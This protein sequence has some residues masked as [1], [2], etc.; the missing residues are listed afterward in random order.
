MPLL[1]EALVEEW[2]NRQGYF[3]IRG[4]RTGVD[5]IDLLAV[6]LT[7]GKPE[8]IHVEA[9]VSFNPVGYIC[10]LPASLANELG[11]AR[12]SAKERSREQM[13]LAT[14][15]WITKKFTQA[16]KR[17][18]RASLMP[19]AT[20]KFMFVHGNVRSAI[21]LELL[22]Q[23]GIRLTAFSEILAALCDSE[24]ERKFKGQAGSDIAD[25]LEFYAATNRE[26]Q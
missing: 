19:T 21:E 26:Q 7:E 11:I 16:R 20:W 22:H 8:A 24:G 15:R 2:L 14:E 18:V 10:P 5:E 6:R 4:I 23:G 1:A 17:E 12:T 3:T 9:Q 25:M 13:K